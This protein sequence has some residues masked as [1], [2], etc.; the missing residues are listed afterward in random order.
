MP[1]LWKGITST[2]Q[3]QHFGTLRMSLRLT[4]AQTAEKRD[5]P[6][7]ALTRKI[8]STSGRHADRKHDGHNN[9]QCGSN[10]TDMKFIDNFDNR[11]YVEFAQEDYIELPRAALWKISEQLPLTKNRQS[12]RQTSTM[13]AMTSCPDATKLPAQSAQM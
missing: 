13:W 11:S 12:G 6:M 10:F 1:S 5:N 9:A 4:K 8:F 3:E 2:W 7:S